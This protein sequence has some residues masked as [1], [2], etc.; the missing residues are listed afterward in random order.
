MKNND[1]S[2]LYIVETANKKGK[3]APFPFIN[4]Q[5]FYKIEVECGL[6]T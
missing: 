2:S 5:F 1:Y 6:K 4:L 3:K